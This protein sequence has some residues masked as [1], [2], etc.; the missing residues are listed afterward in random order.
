M[1]KYTEYISI[2]EF[3]GHWLLDNWMI[4][5]WLD[6]WITMSCK[7]NI[8]KQYEIIKLQIR[9]MNKLSTNSIAVYKFYT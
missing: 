7:S 1:K 6:D 3:S 4:I 2:V 9:T 5:R 8:Y